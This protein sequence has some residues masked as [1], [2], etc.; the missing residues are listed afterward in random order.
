VQAPAP[1]HLI[2]GGIPTEALL[3]RV[4]VSKYADGLPLDRQ[5]ESTLATG[6]TGPLAD[7]PVDGPARFEI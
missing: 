4:A 3:A 7:S 5:E 2:A 6:G 1:D